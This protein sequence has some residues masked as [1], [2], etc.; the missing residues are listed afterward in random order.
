MRPGWRRLRDHA[1]WAVFRAALLLGRVL[2]LSLLRPAGVALARMAFLLA[3]RDR[4]RAIEHLAVAFP[5]METGERSRLL[6]RAVRHVGLI[7]AEVVWLFSARPKQVRDIC[8]LE[9]D[10]HL[11]Q[12]LET[13]RGAVLVTGHC[14]NWEL[15]NARLGVAGIPMTIAVREAYDPR[16]DR[17]ASVLRARF[18]TEVVHR[19]GSAGRRLAGALQQNRVVG[20]L[21]DQD[22]RDVPGVFVPFFGSDAWTPSGAAALALRAGC[23]VVPAFVERLPDGRHRV[24]VH[25]PLPIPDTGDA[26]S[27]VHRLTAAATTAIEAQIR[28]VP[29]QW[30]WHHR[31]WRTRPDDMARRLEEAT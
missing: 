7:F 30:V 5:Q 9:G 13:A 2:P 17:A 29:E 8:D 12:A 21:I 26:A 31:R 23:P 28:R 1:V 6:R 4:R 27:D 22:I 10:E 24:V 25:P 11:R 19:G 15:L 16:V 18:G 3:D 20:L 14:G